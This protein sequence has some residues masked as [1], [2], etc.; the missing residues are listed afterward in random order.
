MSKNRERNDPAYLREQGKRQAREAKQ[1][2][3]TFSFIHHIK[4][5]GQTMAEWEECGLLAQLIERTKYAGQF[6]AV[7]VRQN[8]CIKEYTK[9]DF[10]PDSGFRKPT[11]VGEVTWAVMHIT[12][13]SKEV[14][15]GFIEEDIFH[16]VF[17]DK[18]HQ[19]WPSV[20]KNT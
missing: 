11:H 13:T 7:E 16:I 3:I 20:K 10:P 14:V 1:R 12:N 4:A 9:V 6:T 8:Q 19:F 17:L 15:A 18:E 2:K 5:E